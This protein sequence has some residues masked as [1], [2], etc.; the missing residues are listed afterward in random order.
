MLLRLVVRELTHRVIGTFAMKSSFRQGT[1]LFIDPARECFGVL[2]QS[3]SANENT[4]TKALMIAINLRFWPGDF[5]CESHLCPEG[6]CSQATAHAS[7]AE[8]AA[9]SCA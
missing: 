2:D 1:K 8:L 4:V 9:Y 7:L 6:L 5:G 3:F